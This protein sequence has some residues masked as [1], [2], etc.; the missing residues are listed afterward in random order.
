[1]I[2]L[3]HP[4]VLLAAPP[5]L[6]AL[7]LLVRRPEERPWRRAGS[8]SLRFLALF[9]LA[10]AL[11]GPTIPAS[12]PAPAVVFALDVSDSVPDAALE[13]AVSAIAE[14]SRAVSA[15]SGWS[16]LVLFAG[17]AAVARPPAPEP[18]DFSG[19]LRARVFARRADTEAAA[20]DLSRNAD[21]RWRAD[22]EPLR[23]RA[24]SA[25]VLARSLYRAGAE[26]RT[27]LITDGGETDPEAPLPLDETV[28]VFRLPDLPARDVALR[29]LRVPIA[30]RAGEA[31]DV[32]ADVWSEREEEIRLALTLDGQVV[33]ETEEKRSV[34]A[35]RSTLRIRSVQNSLAQGL[36]RLQAVASA[37]GDA[38][39]RNNSAAASFNVVGKSRVLIVEG[40]PD[41]GE[42][43][44]RLLTAQGIDFERRP[45]ARFPGVAD[46][47]EPWAVVALAGV[48]PARLNPSSA[49]A[50]G[51]WL[52]NGG[53]LLWIGSSAPV[54]PGAYDRP[55][56]TRLLPVEL[57]PP[58]AAPP[59]P[60]PGDG[61]SP[62][63]EV[64][65]PVPETRKVMAPSIALLLIID[66]SGSMSGDPIALC[67]EAAIA[68]LETLSDKDFL[69]V[70]A[71]DRNPVWI[72]P[73]EA[74]HRTEL[75]KKNILR[76][77]ADGGTEVLPALVEAL[78]AFREQEAAK[79]A[80]VKHII[81]LSDGDTTIKNYEKAVKELA[82]EKIVVTSVC[83]VGP[84]GFKDSL[85]RKIAQWGRG[86][87][88]FADSFKKVP[89]I[90]TDETRLVVQEAARKAESDPPRPPPPPAP[91]PGPPS[92]DPPAAPPAT[93]PA[94]GA[95]KVA[96]RDDHEVLRGI[97][98]TAPP[99]P[100]VGALPAKA[101][102][103][104]Y[105]P[106]AF[107]DGAPA[108]ALWRYGLG[109]SA[110]W[111]SDL[112]GP[113]TAG[114]ERWD[115]TTKLFAQVVRHLSNAAEDVGLASAVRVE[116]RGDR[117]TLRID[118]G[119]SV[120]DMSAGKRELSAVPEPDGGRR[121]DLQ[122]EGG[123][124]LTIS[125]ARTREGGAESLPLEFAPGA[126][127]EIAAPPDRPPAFRGISDP[128]RP[129]DRLA[130]EG[131]PPSPGAPA[132][133]TS[134]ATA[135]LLAAALLLPLD[136]AVRRIR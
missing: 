128:P 76:L 132:G 74:A 47:L 110:A 16:S 48:P 86:R 19:D 107:E 59:G 57:E 44:A 41:D 119:V 73:F 38:E 28:R 34:P 6:A 75:I 68:S 37:E 123:E 77:Y 69:G 108:L 45:V 131:P 11:A 33:T 49:R 96:F 55:E 23:T 35:G 78:K 122:L 79:S 94:G 99:P 100:V 32:E 27:L 10:A 118:E 22:L 91:T 56:L 26:N 81:L 112:G 64:P 54:S 20:Q 50:L 67:K 17:R 87:F 84:G 39:P 60:G 14:A 58:K 92:G 115:G 85:M 18:L 72:Q 113:W 43:I 21:P 4:E 121:I 116:R 31:F 71:F 90:F 63:P 2:R 7:L 102:P 109:R 97:P 104:S 101:K 106:L 30:V 136:A 80:G 46:N 135:C 93:A 5:V 61:P 98:R 25:L 42:G 24:A 127:A 130:A 125:I 29:A 9:A 40:S 126:P 3:D 62:N 13:G 66:K 111:T 117:V 89:R 134:L 82:D 114:W 124:P 53:G 65:A 133:R 103:T 51:A 88:F 105:V 120:H 15:R 52:E 70:L 129:L 83:V 8:V 12:P 36:H 1:M 95:R